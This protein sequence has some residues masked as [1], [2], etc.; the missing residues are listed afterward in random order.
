MDTSPDRESLNRDLDHD[1]VVSGAE[2]PSDSE[3]NSRHVY[4][5]QLRRGKYRGLADHR[6]AETG[7][8]ST[9]SRDFR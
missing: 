5:V 3:I 4:Q 6:C 8:L 1:E 9:N 2:P 7:D